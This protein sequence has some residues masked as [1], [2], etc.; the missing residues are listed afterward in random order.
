MQSEQHSPIEQ[1]YLSV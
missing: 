1:N